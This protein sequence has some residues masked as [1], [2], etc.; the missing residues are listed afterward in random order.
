MRTARTTLTTAATSTLLALLALTA[1]GDSQS[2]SEKTAEQF[3]QAVIEGDGETFCSLVAVDGKPVT[4]NDQALETCV[5]M[6][7][8]IE[9]L[10]GDERKEA[11]ESLADGPTKAEENGD[12]AL[13]VYGK[14]DDAVDI[15]LVRIDGDW[16]VRL[17]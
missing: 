1:C 13:V 6:S 8:T 14:G 17:I 11:E 7:D 12:E 5:D 9:V 10:E 2:E 4:E 3:R 15:N 16:F